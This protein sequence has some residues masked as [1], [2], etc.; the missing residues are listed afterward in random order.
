[1]EKKDIQVCA[2]IPVESRMI[3]LRGQ[4]VILDKDVA[5]LYQVKTKHVNQAVKNNPEKFPEGY[6]FELND[7]EMEQ[8]KIFDQSSSRSHYSA[9]AFTEKG[10]YMLATIL[11]GAGRTLRQM[12]D[13][14][15]EEEYSI[16]INLMAFKLSRTI[17]RIKK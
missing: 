17:K 3:S 11:K 5:V 16:E 8:V 15:K 4:M 9:K 10:L 2:D 6:V 7:E 13:E 14:E 12:I 1:M